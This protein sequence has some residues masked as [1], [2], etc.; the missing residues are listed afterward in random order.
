MGVSAVLIGFGYWGQNIARNLYQNPRINFDYLVELNEEHRLNAISLYPNLKVYSR[1]EDY[2]AS[3]EQAKL[4]FVATSASSHFSNVRDLL[5]HDH[6]VWVEK[7]MTLNLEEAGILRDLSKSKAAKVFI[8]HTYL[9]S[10]SITH[11]AQAIETLGNIQHFN[12]VRQGFGKV[13]YD[14]NVVWDL[15]VHDLAILLM[16]AK[17]LPKSV[18]TIAL[19]QNHGTTTSALLHLDFET[20]TATVFCSWLSP[21]KKREMTVLCEKGTIFFD[22]LNVAERVKITKQHVEFQN[23][24]IASRINYRLGETFIPVINNSEPLSNAIGC[25]VDYFQNLAFPLSDAEFGFDI[26][27][28]LDRAEKSLQLN[29]ELVWM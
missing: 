21:L 14:T 20:F 8:D 9:H 13:Q 10:P 4:A 15:A 11:I 1:L 24:S 12:S 5:N 17:R 2:L 23:N 7:P 18:R 27:T 28:I 19:T 3:H 25:F 29:G 26:I 16:L 6:A 22:E